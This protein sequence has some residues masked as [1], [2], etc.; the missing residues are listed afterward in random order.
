MLESSVE[1]VVQTDIDRS[2]IT[3]PS[4]EATIEAIGLCEGAN[5][6]QIGPSYFGASPPL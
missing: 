1:A 3:P 5:L 4:R 2:H 6:V